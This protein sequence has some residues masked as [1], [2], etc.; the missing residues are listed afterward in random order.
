MYNILIVEDD[1]SLS[2]GIVLSLSGAE[3]S[4]ERCASVRE[5]R[6]ALSQRRVYLALLDNGLPDGDGLALCK[7][8][9]RTLSIP[10]LFLTANDAE[11]DEVAGLNAGADDYIVKPFSLAVLRAR[12]EAALRRAQNG[13]EPAFVTGGLYLNFEAQRFE[14]DGRRI[15][16]SRTEQRLLRL[17]VEHHGQTLTRALLLERVWPEGF[18]EDN[19]LSVTVRRLRVKLGDDPERPRIIRTVYALGYTWGVKYDER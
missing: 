4:F 1:A 10:I 17:L 5:A 13:R 2:R 18:V 15:E 3:L 7:E 12:V 11:Y 14:C 6:A 19:A 16:L 8:M 9:R